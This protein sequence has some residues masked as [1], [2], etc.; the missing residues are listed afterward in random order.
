MQRERFIMGIREVL[1]R[2]LVAFGAACAGLFVGLIGSAVVVI[3]A[4]GPGPSSNNLAMAT[5]LGLAVAGA[6]A[7]LAVPV[8]PARSTR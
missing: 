1:F 3:P 6:I 5:A 2:C 4:V 8:E 7:S